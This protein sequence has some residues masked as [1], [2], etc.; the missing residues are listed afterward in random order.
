MSAQQELEKL[1]AIRVE[2]EAESRSLK[3]Q[4]SN[5][6]NSVMFLEEAIAKEEMRKEKA[7]IEELKNYN[8]AAKEAI[9]ELEAKK[10]KLESR[11]E[12]TA[13]PLEPPA[14]KKKRK[15]KKPAEPEAT[16]EEI[17]AEGCGVIVTAID[18]EVLVDEQEAID[19]NPQK[20]EKKKRRFF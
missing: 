7:V 4:Q 3:K 8:K 11:L 12:E 20:Q 6:E 16:P 19:E 13:P 9:V 15:G 5:L 1:Q 10:E 14:T 17:E 2:L 18:G